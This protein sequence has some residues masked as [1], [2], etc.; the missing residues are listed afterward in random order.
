M[1]ILGFSRHVLLSCV[2]SAILAG[3]GGS[4]PPIGAPGAMPQTTANAAHVARHGSWMLPEAKYEDL[5]Y[6]TDY[7]DVLVFS[8]PQGKQVGDLK[9][10]Y[11]SVGDCVDSKGDVF[12]TSLK[13]EA[14]YEYA[15][16]GTKRI[17]T[18]PSK[19]AGAVG[20]SISPTTGDLAVSGWSSYVDI[21]KGAKGRPISIQDA[22]M[23]VGQWCAYDNKGDLFFNGLRNSK[24]KLRLSEL[25]SGSSHFIRIEPDAYVY[26]EGGIYWHDGYLTAVSSDKSK[27]AIAQFQV[28]GRKAHEVGLT[29]LDK[30]AFIVL[31]Y[32]ID[33]KTIVAPN[34]AKD[35]QDSV[36]LYNCPAG[37][38][39]TESIRVVSPRGVVI[40]RAA[41]Q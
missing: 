26:Q 9:H 13:P 4:Q 3:C 7:S 31:G 39:P 33:G 19:K 11:S 15:H 41:Q 24:G 21:Y 25:P 10:F 23:W 6:V 18:L 17:A 40:S 32:F 20:C 34:F 14:T 1:R 16:G 35:E 5:L 2:V 36:L 28:M 38:Q 27:A 30:P 8:Y 29:P 37:G 22:D 12:I